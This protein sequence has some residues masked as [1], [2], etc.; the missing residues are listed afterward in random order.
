MSGGKCSKTGLGVEFAQHREVVVRNDPHSWQ[1][2]CHVQLKRAQ[3]SREP[4]Q[5]KARTTA[6]QT[7]QGM[8]CFSRV[9]VAERRDLLP[10]TSV[11]FGQSHFSQHSGQGGDTR[12]IVRR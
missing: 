4:C 2:T 7:V 1:I 5:A 10:K 8:R 6:L 9:E 11:K 3:P 12:Q